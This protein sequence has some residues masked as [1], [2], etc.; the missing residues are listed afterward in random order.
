MSK[1]RN[2]TGNTVPPIEEANAFIPSAVDRLF[3][4]QWAI[5]LITMPNTRPHEICGQRT[6]GNQVLKMRNSDTDTNADAL[7]K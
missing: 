1:L 3:L 4:N 5:T 2:T 7:E 6:V